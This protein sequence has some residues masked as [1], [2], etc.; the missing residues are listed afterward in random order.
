LVT[1]TTTAAGSHNLHIWHIQ[2]QQAEYDEQGRQDASVETEA[3]QDPAYTVIAAHP[4][5]IISI[6]AVPAT[7]RK[8]NVAFVTCSAGVGT[9]TDGTLRNAD[10]GTVK[11]WT[12]SGTP[13]TMKL[14]TGAS[15]E[16]LWCKA[17]VSKVIVT[18][19]IE[20]H[21]IVAACSEPYTEIE[22]WNITTG[23]YMTWDHAGMCSNLSVPIAVVLVRFPVD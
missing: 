5:V 17:S 2:C 22:L 8:D 14:R 23:T 6:C 21:T 13:V 12:S 1:A 15:V 4:N 11:L 18:V 7:P 10:C 20:S 3:V 9:Q 19:N 16:D